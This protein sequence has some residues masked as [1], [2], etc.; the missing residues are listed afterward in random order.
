MADIVI[1]C[2]GCGTESKV[3]QYAAAE[4]VSC[5]SCK[6][7]LEL[8][9][10]EAGRRKLEMRRLRAEEHGTLTGTAEQV[11]ADV[12]GRGIEARQVEEVLDNVHRA[13]QKVESPKAIWGW[14]VF[15]LVAGALVGWQYLG[16]NEPRLL[17]QYPMARI[18]AL[19]LS[20]LMVL[21]VAFQDST[22][23]GLLCLFA[24]LYILYYA[25]VRMEYYV[26][27]GIFLAVVLALG[28]E[29][30]FMRDD[31]LFT[32]AQIAANKGIENVSR[33]ISRASDAPDMPRHVRKSRRQRMEE[34]QQQSRQN[35]F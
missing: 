6:R 16:S 24:P 17:A 22:F 7:R 13:R 12:A 19:A 10:S 3:S 28:T 1:K 23:Q 5:P 8:P 18:A 32:H 4:N 9:K 33:L 29:L 20:T 35:A 30:Y 15:I 2:P 11:V 26:I 27:R 14:L 25:F 34:Q 31:A 21:L